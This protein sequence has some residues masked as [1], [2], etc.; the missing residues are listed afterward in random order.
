MLNLRQKTT[1]SGEEKR[2]NNDLIENVKGLT[3]LQ[4][5]ALRKKKET[6]KLTIE[7]TIHYPQ[8]LEDLLEDFSDEIGLNT[9]AS[10]QFYQFILDAVQAPRLTDEDVQ[11]MAKEFEE[12]IMGAAYKEI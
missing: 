12:E 10:K 6:G 9:N 4:N 11:R 8:P 7:R 3:I 5:I 2:E 1:I